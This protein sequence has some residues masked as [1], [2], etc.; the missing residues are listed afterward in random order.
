MTRIE[1]SIE[2]PE[3]TGNDCKIELQKDLIIR[4]ALTPVNQLLQNYESAHFARTGLKVLISGP[5][6]AGKS[7]LLNAL[8]ENNRAIVTPFPGTTRDYIESEVSINDLQVTLIDT[9]GLHDT[10]DPIERHGIDLT[11]S[12]IN[13]VDLILFVLDVAQSISEYDQWAFSMLSQKPVIVVFNKSDIK[14]HKAFLSL[15]DTW[16]SIDQ[17]H[18]SAKTGLGLKH[19]K[20]IITDFAIK[21][22]IDFTNDLIPNYRQKANLEHCRNALVDIVDGINNSLP[23]DLISMDIQ[24]AITTLDIILGKSIDNDVLDHIFDQFCIGK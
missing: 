1:A 9:A 3:E 2:F 8:S 17:V 10:N 14:K 24:E 22:K 4:T 20:T 19:L 23:Y 7:T 12:F 5:P 13:D 15:P 18:I 6:N 11:F 16:N 21:D